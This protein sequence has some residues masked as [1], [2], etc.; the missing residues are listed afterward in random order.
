MRNIMSDFHVQES[1]KL[2]EAYVK[3]TETFER[4]TDNLQTNTLAMLA[5]MA[6]VASM[7]KAWK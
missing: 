5:V 1:A 3:N 7:I 6:D 2:R 4:L